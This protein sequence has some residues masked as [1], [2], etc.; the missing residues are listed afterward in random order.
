VGSRYG[1]PRQ[2]RTV[3]VGGRRRRRRPACAGCRTQSSMAIA[4]PSSLIPDTEAGAVVLHR[5]RVAGPS[6]ARQPVPVEAPWSTTSKACRRGAHQPLLGTP[7]R[8]LVWRRRAAVEHRCTGGAGRT[9][10]ALPRCAAAAHT[11]PHPGWTKDSYTG[12][13]ILTVG[14]ANSGNTDNLADIR[15]G[16]IVALYILFDEGTTYLGAPTDPGLST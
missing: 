3:W 1:F 6:R 10:H 11:F 8:R 15:A 4:S 12:D 9:V 16:T 5:D 14:A 13:D 7:R 2:V